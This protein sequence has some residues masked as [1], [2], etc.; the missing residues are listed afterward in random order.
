M[1]IF[2]Y[3][4][5]IKKGYMLL[6]TFAS[7]Y[8]GIIFYAILKVVYDS[9]QILLLLFNYLTIIAME[10]VALSTYNTTIIII[11]AS[12]FLFGGIFLFWYKIL[13][14]FYLPRFF[15]ILE[16]KLQAIRDDTLNIDYM[17]GC[18]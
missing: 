3:G 8:L 15:D 5:K 14:K 16:G 4:P 2:I 7:A 13:L 1:G 18:I 6:L 11:Y 9:L 10:N 17:K 12:I